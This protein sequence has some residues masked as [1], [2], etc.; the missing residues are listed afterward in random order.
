MCF[1]LKAQGLQIPP[2]TLTHSSE[3]V[4]RIVCVC[5]CQCQNI[6]AWTSNYAYDGCWREIQWIFTPKLLPCWAFQEKNVFWLKVKGECLTQIFSF[7]WW[8]AH[9]TCGWRREW[10]CIHFSSNEQ[11]S[12][13]S[14]GKAENFD[15]YEG[16]KKIYYIFWGFYYPFFLLVLLKFFCHFKAPEIF[17]SSHWWRSDLRES[18]F[19]GWNFPYFNE[20]FSISTGI[21]P[22]SSIRSPKL[23]AISQC[24]A[25][26]STLPTRTHQQHSK[27]LIDFRRV[28]YTF[29]FQV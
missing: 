11:L 23:L 22:A 27:V 28:Q 18:E 8:I 26:L 5:R 13:S 20:S 15:F 17:H 16:W 6:L 1:S 14:S 24:P 29:N 21:W 12:S 10:N 9:T 3:F 25:C 19:M 7:S 4:T 2:S